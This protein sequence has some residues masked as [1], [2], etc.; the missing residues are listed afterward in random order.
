[1]PGSSNTGSRVLK[2]QTYR[3][4]AQQ[5]FALADGCIMSAKK[6]ALVNMGGFLALRDLDLAVQCRTVLIITEGYSTYGGLSGRDMEAIAIGLEEVFDADYLHY[7]IKS[8]EYLAEKL[9]NSAS[10]SCDRRAGTRFTWML[11]FSILKFRW[12]NIRA[13]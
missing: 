5:M 13:R 3:E 7:R 2:T 6:D 12:I 1:M 10:R 8:T 4:I 11:A 9:H